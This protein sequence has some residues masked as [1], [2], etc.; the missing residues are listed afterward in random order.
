MAADVAG[1]DEYGQSGQKNTAEDGGHMVPSE[2]P[3]TSFSAGETAGE[4]DSPPVTT[5]GFGNKLIAELDENKPH[6]SPVD[7]PGSTAEPDVTTDRLI[8]GAGEGA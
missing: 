6:E 5:I 8:P 7:P 1:T 2:A 3:N 4:L